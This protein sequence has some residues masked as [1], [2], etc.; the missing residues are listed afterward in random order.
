MQGS[1][2]RPGNVVA[3]WPDPGFG[4]EKNP[5]NTFNFLSSPM[6]NGSHVWI[7]TLHPEIDLK[8]TSKW[9]KK[10]K[11]EYPKNASHFHENLEKMKGTFVQTK[12]K[13]NPLRK[14]GK[15]GLR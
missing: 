10:E 8:L 15:K 6:D 1:N 3:T 5:L 13:K 2:A 14:E 9:K 7:K 12:R 11:L 4:I